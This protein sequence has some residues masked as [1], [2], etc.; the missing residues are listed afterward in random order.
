MQYLGTMKTTIDIPEE[1]L[2]EAMKRTGARTRRDAIVAA[3]REFNRRH[4]LELLAEQLQGSCPNFMTH[5]NLRKIRSTGGNRGNVEIA[6]SALRSLRYFRLIIVSLL[7]S[8][9]TSINE[10]KHRRFLG[11]PHH[12]LKLLINRIRLFQF[13][14]HAGHRFEEAQ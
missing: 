10:N 5:P 8:A 11:L 4:R 14:L 9:A 2:T 3:V 13:G 1:L 7:T 12:I 6:N